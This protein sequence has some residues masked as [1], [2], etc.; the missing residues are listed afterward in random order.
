MFN[1][2]LLYRSTDNIPNGYYIQSDFEES[3]IDYANK[4][5]T[6]SSGPNHFGV[7][8]ERM[9]N[10]ITTESTKLYRFYYA[11]SYEQTYVRYGKNNRYFVRAEACH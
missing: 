8:H 1:K 2:Q 6:E 4:G 3:L 11:V 5:W 10:Y 7:K 9:W